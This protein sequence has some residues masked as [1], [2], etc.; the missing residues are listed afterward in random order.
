VT[1][2]TTPIRL[3]LKRTENLT[4]AWQDGRVCTY[5]LSLLRS[6]CPCAQC[7]TIREGEQKKKPMLTILP[8]NY[9][10]P[11]TVVNAQLVGNY[12]LKIEWSDQHDSGIYSFEYL[13][14]ICPPSA[15]A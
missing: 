11:I 7:R 2:S 8:G 10:G 12:A 13:R 3:D 6:M 15:P 14:E 9:S 5:S 1:P 4:I